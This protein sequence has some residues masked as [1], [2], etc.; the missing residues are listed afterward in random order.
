MSLAPPEPV[1]S[2]PVL[3]LASDLRAERAAK[4]PFPPG[5]VS[6]SAARTRRMLVDP[7]HLLLE[8]HERYGPVFTLRIFHGQTVFMIGP[9]ANHHMLVSHAKDF[10]WRE[11]HM[12]DL[13]P[14]L[15]DGLLTIDGEFHRRSRK[16]MLPAFH[17]ERIA[18]LSELMDDEIETAVGGWRAGQELDLYGWTRQ[19]AMRI[20]MR[21][22]FGMDPLRSAGRADAAHLFEVALGFWGQP[23]IWQVMRGPRTPWARMQQ[24]RRE[25]DALIYSEID[26]RRASGERGEDILSLLIDAADEDGR[27]LSK[28]HVRDEVMTLLFAGH[29]TTTS[30]VTFLFGELAL[31]PE[32]A[33]RAAASDDD[34]EL[35]LDETLRRYPAG[36]DR[37]A[38]G[39]GRLR[40]RRPHRP[41][42]R[43]RQLR[44][45][46]HPPPARGLGRAVRLPPR[47]LR[48]RGAQADPQG[49]LRPVRR[50]LADLHRDALRPA[51]DPH[52][53]PPHPPRLPPRA[54]RRPPHEDPPDAHHRPDRRP[55]GDHPRGGLG[56]RRSSATEGVWRGGVSWRT[57]AAAG[58]EPAPGQ[59]D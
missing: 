9:E 30:T 53:G 37:P 26:R 34:L 19:L 18:A 17:S 40:V 15:G 27:T 6:F 13:I 52:D 25:L 21:A 20:A 2:N 41:R 8:A 51:G 12:G 55:A 57:L 46:G 48:A 39:D 50:R 44:V 38:Q 3:R 43:V 58:G 49:R 24:A 23:Y 11:G 14:L 28:Q 47:A 42:G 5:D 1:S 22:L 10:S 16:V 54:A 33:D 36:L 29:D 7:L 31:A 4:V 35:C 56:G 45:L 59:S 32:W